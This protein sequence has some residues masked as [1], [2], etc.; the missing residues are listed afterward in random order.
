MLIHRALGINTHA[1]IL[2]KYNT[3]ASSRTI[4]VYY[5]ANKTTYAHESLLGMVDIK[6]S[7]I[8]YTDDGKND[9]RKKEKQQQPNYELE[10]RLFACS[11]NMK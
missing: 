3:H 7:R 8:M 10:I 6:H 5:N 2:H 1:R 4:Y 9:E 11:H